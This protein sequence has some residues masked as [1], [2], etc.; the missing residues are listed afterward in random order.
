MCVFFYMG[1]AVLNSSSHAHTA[2]SVL[3]SLPT[4]L[5]LV[6]SLLPWALFVSL[7]LLFLQT[8]LFVSALPTA[9]RKPGVPVPPAL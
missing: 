9:E 2:S 4:A 5:G 6:F 1:S 3:Q 7:P 8:R